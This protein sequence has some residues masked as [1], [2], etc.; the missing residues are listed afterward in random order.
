MLNFMKIHNRCFFG[1]GENLQKLMQRRLLLSDYLLPFISL[2]FYHRTHLNLMIKSCNLGYSCWGFLGDGITDTPDGG[3][4]HRS[5]LIKTILKEGYQV[6][7]LQAD[8]DLLEA[9]KPIQLGQVYDA[10]FPEIDLLFLEWRW[11]IPN[12]NDRKENPYYTPD[13]FRQLELISHYSVRCPILIWDKDKTF[14]KTP[15][16]VLDILDNG[17]TYIIEPSL[18]PSKYNIFSALFPFDPHNYKKNVNCP[19]NAQTR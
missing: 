19:I 11:I 15:K 5:Y 4:S 14:Y 12:R 6:I 13:W 18:M 17:K 9:Q 1:N 10:G 2:K 3:R 16:A 7:M 8:R